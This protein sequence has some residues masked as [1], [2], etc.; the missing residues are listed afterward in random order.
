MNKLREGVMIEQ[1]EGHTDGINCLAMASDE[2]VLVS[3]S[4]DNTARI[5]TLDD[6][7][8]APVTYNALGQPM[9]EVPKTPPPPKEIGEAEEEEKENKCIGILV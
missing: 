2:S 3:G 6:H 5:W 9:P 8:P 4:E 7:P 1:F